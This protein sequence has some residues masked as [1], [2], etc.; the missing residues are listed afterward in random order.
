MF[1]AEPR[2]LTPCRLRGTPPAQVANLSQQF[3]VLEPV[4]TQAPEL[5]MSVCLC[6]SVSVSV[7][8]YVCLSCLSVCLRLSEASEASEA[9]IVTL[10]CW[11]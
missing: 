11:C 1:A 8:L 2:R 7:C 5:H 9:F 6:L 3:Q 10:S 4:Q